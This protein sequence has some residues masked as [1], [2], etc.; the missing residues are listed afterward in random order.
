MKKIILV[1]VVLTSLIFVGYIKAKH[2]WFGKTLS[3]RQVCKKWG[4]ASFDEEKFRY[5]GVNG[6]AERAKMACSLLRSQKK[7]VGKNVDEV[8]NLFGKY[9]GYYFSDSIPA[10][11]IEIGKTAEEDSWQIVLLIDK[12]NNISKIIVHKNCCD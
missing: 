11:L 1:F 4:D 7:Y 2:F 5:A 10:Y 8:I 9:N 12:Q 6:L 3:T